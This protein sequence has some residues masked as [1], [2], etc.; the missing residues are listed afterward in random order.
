VIE[1]DG[2]LD[3]VPLLGRRDE[4][5]RRNQHVLVQRRREELAGDGIAAAGA[6]VAPELGC[7]QADLDQGEIA[8]RQRHSRGKITGSRV[9]GDK[10][11]R[12]LE[13]ERGRE[14]SAKNEDQ[15]EHGAQVDPARGLES[16]CRR[17]G[18]GSH[19]GRT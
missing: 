6:E 18:G 16:V 10:V 19:G 2:Q 8:V 13:H 1:V 14:D 3:H 7:G 4:A 9:D 5:I 15:S 17:R 11:L 12:P